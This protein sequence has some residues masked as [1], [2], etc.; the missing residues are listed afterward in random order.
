MISGH[1]VLILVVVASIVLMLVRPR[2]IAEVYWIG[3]GALLLVVL[4]L[5]PLGLAGRAIA[6]GTDVYLFLTGMMLLSELARF[7]GV[8]DWLAEVAVEH[9]RGSRTRLFTLIYAVGTVVTIFMSNDATAVVL[10]PAVFTAVRRSKGEPLPYLFACALIANAASFVLPISNPANLV[11]FRTRM[12]PLVHWLAAFTLP[13][14]LSIAA[15]YLVLRWYLRRDLAGAVDD[16]DGIGRLNPAGKLV[17]IG[18]WIVAGVLLAA[19][20]LHKDLGL[21]A[22]LSAVVVSAVVLV[23]TQTNPMRIVRDISWSILPLVAGLFILMEAIVS[24]GALRYT[25]AALAWADRLP[26]AP[27]AL[28]TG[29]VVGV[30]NNLINNLPLGL[31]AGSTLNSQHVQGVIE[32]AVLIGVDLGPNL[33]VTGSLATILWLIAIRRE[34]LHVSFGTFLKV[35][36]IAMP[37][38]LALALVSAALL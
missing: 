13:S 22:C 37:V 17:F 35:G 14:V 20:A 12:P 1:L 25:A 2:G 11:V 6:A 27:G 18:V 4:R 31:I 15:T 24:I 30:G 5:V 19:S 10:T 26:R 34:G 16:G 36:V 28:L 23:K 38:A 33:S 32:N 7:Y 8:F 9:A 3:G 29:A 21:P